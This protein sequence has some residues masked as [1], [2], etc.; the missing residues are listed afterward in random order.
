MKTVRSLRWKLVAV[1]LVALVLAA[2]GGEV[3]SPQEQEEQAGGGAEPTA[4]GGTEGA[5]AGGSGADLTFWTWVPNIENEVALFEEAHP[6]ISVEVVNVGQGAPHYQRLRTALEAGTGAPDVA[7]IE[8]QYIPSFTITESLLDLAPHG[9]NEIADDYVG[10]TWEQV[11]DGDQVW[12]IPQDTGPMGLL[13]RQDIFDEHGIEV[14]A[15]WEEFAQAAR[16]LHEADPDVFITNLPP[17]DPGQVNSLFW[18]AGS[19]PFEVDGEQIA[20]NINDDPA[21][22]V[23]EYWQQ[24]NDEGLIATDPDF[25]DQWY[26]SFNQGRYAT[27][28]SAAWGPVFLTDAIPD[29]AGLWRAAPLPQWEEGG[30]ASANWGGST[31]AVTVQTQNPE[32]AA[33]LAMWL[34]HDP[35]STMMFATEQFLFPALQSILEDPA[36]VDQELEFYGGQQVNQIFAESSGQVNTGFQFSPFQDY[37]YSQL[38]DTYGAALAEGGDLVGALSTLQDNVT[39]Y[40]ESQGFTVE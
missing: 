4:D 39:G 2:C 29:T 40:A 18:Q 32:A 9:A 23:A 22:Q 13:Y 27:W 10:W 8:F 12:A 33:E 7:Q 15:T 24:L 3:E 17:N 26:Q 35:E 16:D 30:T 36:F 20:I 14:P 11:S 25:T 6:D 5:E 19:R 28:I 21:V 38:Q 31:N 34:N 1:A 37:V